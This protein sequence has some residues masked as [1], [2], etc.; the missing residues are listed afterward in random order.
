MITEITHTHSVRNFRQEKSFRD[1]GRDHGAGSRQDDR[2]A[3]M[4]LFPAAALASGAGD[5]PRQATGQ[6]T[7]PAGG[8]ADELEAQTAATA[9]ARR[10]ALAAKETAG[11]V[12]DKDY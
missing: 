11:D 3:R 10:A 4:W 6:H 2:I 9:H 5:P 8:A 12:P 7:G 1:H